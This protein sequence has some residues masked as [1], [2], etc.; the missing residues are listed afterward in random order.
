MLGTE[1]LWEL[2]QAW[3]GHQ[4]G[5]LRTGERY[6]VPGE[7]RQWLVGD[8]FKKGERGSN[9]VYFSLYS[10]TVFVGNLSVANKQTQQLAKTKYQL[11]AYAD[12]KSWSRSHRLQMWL[13][14]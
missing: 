12:E 8:G 10:G 14:P 2:A 13:V 3:V 5:D 1:A 7:K 6:W 11:L 9:L 4:D